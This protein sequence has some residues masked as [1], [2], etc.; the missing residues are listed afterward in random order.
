ME[1][2]NALGD[3]QVEATDRID[4]RIG[5][6]PTPSQE[7]A[8]REGGRSSRGSKRAFRPASVC[9]SGCRRRRTLL[10][11]AGGSVR[12]CAG[13]LQRLCSTLEVARRTPPR[14]GPK[15]PRQLTSV[16]ELDGPAVANWSDHHQESFHRDPCLVERSIIARDAAD[17]GQSARETSP[18]KEKS[19]RV[20]VGLALRGSPLRGAGG[21]RA[22]SRQR[23]GPARA[24]VGSQRRWWLHC[25]SGDTD[26]E[27]KVS[28]MFDLE[29]ART[30]GEA[31]GRACRFGGIG[32]RGGCAPAS[33][34]SL[35]SPPGEG[36]GSISASAVARRPVV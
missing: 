23:Q 25:R 9:G 34:L 28:L 19:S 12:R 36:L 4:H 22:S 14:A 35:S 10:D 5:R 16:A 11:R 24:P 13:V 18:R 15:E 32:G 27:A 3:N 8:K 6:S 1:R 33:R 30:W 29:Q 7:T 26:S 21:T 2:S 20:D 17:T 31:G